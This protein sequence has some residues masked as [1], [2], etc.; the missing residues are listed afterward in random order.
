MGELYLHIYVL[1]ICYTV[2]RHTIAFIYILEERK[3]EKGGGVSNSCT[4][5]SFGDVSN[6]E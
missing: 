1:T 6:D 4:L 5:P 2:Y 3:R